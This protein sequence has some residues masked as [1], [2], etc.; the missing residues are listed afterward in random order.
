MVTRESG[1]SIVLELVVIKVRPRILLPFN[2]FYR[3]TNFHQNRFIPH[4]IPYS[5][6]NTVKNSQSK[7]RRCA[8]RGRPRFARSRE[9]SQLRCS[10]LHTQHTTLVAS[11]LESSPPHT[12]THSFVA[13]LLTHPPSSLFLYHLLASLVVV[14]TEQTRVASLRSTTPHT[15]DNTTETKERPSLPRRPQLTPLSFSFFPSLLS[16]HDGRFGPPRLLPSVVDSASP[17]IYE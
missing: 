12:H 1:R 10:T 9:W 7:I 2:I 16:F 11:L 15:R 6:R 13:S 4:R 14:V 17:I 3:S 5:P 8:A